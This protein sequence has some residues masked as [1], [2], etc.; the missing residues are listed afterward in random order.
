MLDAVD[1]RILDQL[2]RD[3][4]L[5]NLELAAR[6]HVSPA[7]ALRRTKSLVEAGYIERT[8]ALLSPDKL[9]PGLSAIV[10]VMLEPQTAQTLDAFEA[11]AIADPAV[12]QC[13]RTASGPDFVLFATVPD[14]PAWH[15]F[16]QRVMTDDAH[17]R[18]VRNYFVAKRAKFAPA[19][20]LPRPPAR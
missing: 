20:P 1:L 19:I 17:V 4:S 5:T 18:N 2:Q 9:A 8:V 16:L 7:T 6:V 12:Q 14:M 3:A 10:E 11:R 15:A 13:Y